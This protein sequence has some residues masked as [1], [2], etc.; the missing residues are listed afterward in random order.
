MQTITEAA[1][2]EIWKAIRQAIYD[3]DL[4]AELESSVGWIP[5][6]VGREIGKAAI[7]AVRKLQD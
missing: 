6:E 2:E 7:E 5:M 4:D 3:A 1:Y